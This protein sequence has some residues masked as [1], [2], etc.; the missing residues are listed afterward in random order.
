MTLISKY[1][2]PFL[3]SG[4]TKFEIFCFF[5]DLPAKSALSLFPPSVEL[6]LH[7]GGA[8]SDRFIQCIW[9]NGAVLRFDMVE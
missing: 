3:D 9:N 6:V 7:V 2:W 4:K 8:G 5:H 1:M